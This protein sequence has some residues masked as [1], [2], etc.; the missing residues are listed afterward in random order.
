MRPQAPFMKIQLT[1]FDT[2]LFISAITCP[3]LSTPPHMKVVCDG[4]LVNSKCTFECYSGYRR[5]GTDSRTCRA[6]GQWSGTQPICTGLLTTWGIILSAIHYTVVGLLFDNFGIHQWIQR[7]VQHRGNV[8]HEM[9]YPGEVFGERFQNLGKC[10]NCPLI[11]H[12]FKK[13]VTL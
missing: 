12:A 8:L 7:L 6:D 4:D 11:S 9:Q 13:S 5:N 3:A 2:V 10:R 1:A